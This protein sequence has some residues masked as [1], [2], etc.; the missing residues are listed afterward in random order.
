[1]LENAN[2][3]PVKKTNNPY[4]PLKPGEK[5][6][7]G[8]PAKTVDINNNNN[9]EDW[10]AQ[11]PSSSDITQSI[12]NMIDVSTENQHL[13]LKASHLEQQLQF[14]ITNKHNLKEEINEDMITES[15]LAD[16]KQSINKKNKNQENSLV[17]RFINIIPKLKKQES[18]LLLDASDKLDLLSFPISKLVNLKQKYK[19]KLIDLPY[20]FRDNDTINILCG[21]QRKYNGSKQSFPIM[22]VKSDIN[23][24]IKYKLFKKNT[25]THQDGLKIILQKICEGNSSHSIS[26]N[27]F[28][29]SN[30]EI[31]N[32][33]NN[34]EL[35]INLPYSSTM[36]ELC[37]YEYPWE[38]ENSEMHKITE[39]MG[40]INELIVESL[41]YF[42]MICLC[43]PNLCISLSQFKYKVI[44]DADYNPKNVV[45]KLY[46]V[47][48]DD[49]EAIDELDYAGHLLQDKYPG[50]NK[51]KHIQQRQIKKQ[52]IE[53][54]KS[55]IFDGRIQTIWNNVQNSH[56]WLKIM[57]LFIRNEFR[58]GFILDSNKRYM[59]M[60]NNI[61]D[62]LKTPDVV[63][64]TFIE[65]KNNDCIHSSGNSVIN[66]ISVNI[67]NDNNLNAIDVPID[68]NMFNNTAI[69]NNNNN[70][71]NL[72]TK[73]YS[74][75]NSLF[76]S[77]VKPPSI[78]T[79]GNNI[80][81][82]EE[83]MMTFSQTSQ[84]K[85][86][87]LSLAAYRNVHHISECNKSIGDFHNILM[88]A[89]SN[90]L[91]SS[92]WYNHTN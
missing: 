26:Y 32:I 12:Y 67:I 15:K 28:F 53:I 69:N 38:Q 47:A 78:F 64:P 76:K 39:L 18:F 16:L 90:N 49:I 82:S 8:R 73:Q 63:I 60:T 62:F 35:S 31:I 45:M 44:L 42:W 84:N 89:S 70:N 43:L 1:M 19:S 3:S 4:I 23:D 5:R 85:S 58:D 13:K 46:N 11:R 56:P 77:P 40:E 14:Q 25:L 52:L 22:L 37:E 24:E 66:N 7:R 80:Q 92:S 57:E 65:N 86:V 87:D 9:K 50:S 75:N 68:Y 71:N 10:K 83:Q 51:P 30:I 48:I 91:I 36:Y 17:C 6:K 81:D 54:A 59:N 27:N 72:L 34:R 2:K 29:T 88:A 33:H 41:M 79:I 20:I 61:S 21:N 55:M 74:N